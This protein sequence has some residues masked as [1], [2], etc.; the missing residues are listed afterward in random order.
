MT[1]QRDCRRVALDQ[2]ELKRSTPSELISC[3]SAIT[4]LNGFLN[5]I[6]VLQAMLAAN[7]GS[8]KALLE[9]L[10]NL[11]DDFVIFTKP[12]NANEGEPR[13]FAL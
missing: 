4:T 1:I 9:T 13:Y 2:A 7:P 3:Y 12:S 8:E 6:I 10:N 5:F 11:R